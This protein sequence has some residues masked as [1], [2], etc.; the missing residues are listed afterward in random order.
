[1]IDWNDI[2]AAID[3]AARDWRERAAR[4]R[5][6]RVVTPY[7]QSLM[8]R[9]GKQETEDKDAAAFVVF[10]SLRHEMAPEAKDGIE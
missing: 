5:R 2:D 8:E 9:L 4:A 6:R 7:L 10:D 3:E 1:M